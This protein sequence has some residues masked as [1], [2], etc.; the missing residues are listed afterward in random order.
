MTLEELCKLS[1][2]LHDD[3]I[4]I[5]S[6]KKV[7]DD[8]INDTKTKINNLVNL[9]DICDKSI[10]LLTEAG[11][12][13]RDTARQHFEK[14]ITNALQFITQSTDYE[15]VIQELNERS[16]ASYEFYIKSNVNGIESLQKPQDANGG[17]FVDIIALVAKYAYLEIFD[18]PKIMS[19]T[20]LLDEP[21]KMI[22]KDMSI[23]FGEYIKYL[24]T[25]YNRQA[26]MVTHSEELSAIAN[27]TFR[28]VKDLKGYS[29]VF[30]ET[31]VKPN[32]NELEEELKT[33]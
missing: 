30:E 29:H 22:S 26:I 4:A 15:F 21:G 20:L 1:D 10:I 16:K 6:E 13:S 14:I 32:L 33:E 5:S 11:K 25:Q 2:S 9:S 12:L 31:Y 17:G 19:G 23:K 7:L 28:V 24:G 8:Q 18:D 27:E 3:I